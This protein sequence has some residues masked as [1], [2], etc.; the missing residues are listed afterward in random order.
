MDVEVRRLRMAG[1][2]RDDALVCAQ[3]TCGQGISKRGFQTAIDDYGSGFATLDW[4]IELKPDILKL[5]M[6]LIRDIDQHPAKQF[7]VEQTVAQCGL[8]GTKVLAE[9]IE[10]RAELDYLTSVGIRYLQGYYFAKPQLE[11]LAQTAEL[12][13]LQ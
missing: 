6:Q 4:L 1:V 11:T 3:R 2:A 8:Q 12:S 9:G 7:I 10:T 13:G 5:D